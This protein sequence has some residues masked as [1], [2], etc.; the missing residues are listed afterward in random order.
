MKTVSLV[1]C[2]F[3]CF[4]WTLHPAGLNWLKATLVS[5]LPQMEKSRGVHVEIIKLEKNVN[6]LK[7]I[8]HF[9]LD[10]HFSTGMLK[11][12][13]S[14]WEDHK[15]EAVKL[16]QIFWMQFFKKKSWHIFSV[17]SQIINILGFVGHTVS[18]T[19][20]QLCQVSTKAAMNRTLRN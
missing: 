9:S 5:G 10:W 17:K 16:C 18:I 11:C 15:F 6:N 2:T 7:I 1:F 4:F 12:C 20:T 19:I 13:F 3:T 14:R 8:R